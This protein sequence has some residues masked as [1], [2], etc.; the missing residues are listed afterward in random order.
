VLAVLALAATIASALLASA[1]LRRLR[2][3]ELLRDL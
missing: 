1:A 2:P 3:I